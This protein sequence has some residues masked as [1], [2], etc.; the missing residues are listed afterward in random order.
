[1]SDWTAYKQLV[2][3]RMS[4]APPMSG[5]IGLKKSIIDLHFSMGA[6]LLN[7]NKQKHLAQH[8][9]WVVKATSNVTDAEEYTNL[10]EWHA[11]K[12]KILQEE[13]VKKASRMKHWRK[14]LADIEA[15]PKPRRSA[16][17]YI[18]DVLGFPWIIRALL[19]GRNK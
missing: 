18:S 8:A 4:Y 3:A 13:I 5:R 15:E 19:S 17:D 7:I 9:A 1:M 6:D 2:A 10:A 12:T 14:L 11:H 16:L